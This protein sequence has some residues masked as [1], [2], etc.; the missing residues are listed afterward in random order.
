MR[1]VVSTIY[2][3]R[4]NEETKINHP[5]LMDFDDKTVRIELRVPSEHHAYMHPGMKLDL[6]KTCAKQ[7]GAY[8]SLAPTRCNRK[9]KC[10]RCCDD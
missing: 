4:C 1:N 5:V 2:C 7:V 10:V 6:C 3:D 9:C 8:L